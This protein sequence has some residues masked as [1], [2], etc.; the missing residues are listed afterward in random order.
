M[1]FMAEEKTISQMVFQLGCELSR[2]YK[3]LTCSFD[4]VLVQ[5]DTNDIFFRRSVKGNCDSFFF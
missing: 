2:S 3:L 5:C 1:E 4:T